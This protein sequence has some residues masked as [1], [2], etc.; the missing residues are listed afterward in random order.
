MQHAMLQI[1]S[2]KKIKFFDIWFAFNKKH[3]SFAIMMGISVGYVLGM[4]VY[5]NTRTYIVL[6]I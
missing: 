2:S 3:W 1:V 4:H 6:H 5:V